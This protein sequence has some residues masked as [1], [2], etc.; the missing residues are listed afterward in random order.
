MGW[1]GVGY[2][3][4]DLPLFPLSFD[5]YPS[6]SHTFRQGRRFTGH[7]MINLW[8]YIYTYFFLQENRNTWICTFGQV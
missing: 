7:M 1:G 6:L 8:L 4:F 2:C 5:S 3:S